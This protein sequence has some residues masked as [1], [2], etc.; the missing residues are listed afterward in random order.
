MLLR[1]PTTLRIALLLWLSV[2]AS[3]TPT[4]D[5]IAARRITDP[6]ATMLHEVNIARAARGSGP[7]S[8]DPQLTQA[9]QTHTDDMAAA[10]RLGHCGFAGQMSRIGSGYGLFVENV[11]AGSA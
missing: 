9:A 1:L 4:T 3:V 5:G 11:F 2:L 7:V 6:V 10:G 8:F